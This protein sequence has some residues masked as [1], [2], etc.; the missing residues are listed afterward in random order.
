M[1]SQ[2]R[3]S[4]EWSPQFEQIVMG[5]PQVKGAVTKEAN[6]IAERANGMASTVSGIWHETGRPHDPNKTGGKWHDHGK[7]YPTIGGNEAAYRS[8]PAKMFG[9]KPVAIVYSAN[10]AAQKDNYEHNTLLKAKG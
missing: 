4:V 5:L 9:G 6:A 3:V 10:Y 2:I 7:S 8:K 1:A